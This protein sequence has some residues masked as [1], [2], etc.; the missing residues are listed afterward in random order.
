MLRIVTGVFIAMATLCVSNLARAQE[1]YSRAGWY[2]GLGGAVAFPTGTDGD[3]SL[4]LN[5]RAGYRGKWAGGEV[6]FEWFES[7]DTKLA[8]DDA[9]ALTLDGKLYFLAGL[10]DT[11]PPLAR[12]FQP[13]A[14][15]GFGYM[16]FDFPSAVPRLTTLQALEYSDL[17]DWDFVIRAGAGLDVY[18]TRNIA[19]SVDATYVF[20]TSNDLDELEWVSFGWGLL[21]R[22]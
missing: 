7:L 1:D 6:H 19:I 20:A 9:W 18:L 3:E 10:E 11:L 2:L 17:D 22:F 13:F 4:G 5:A 21:Y 12:R 8:I 14:T 15:A 16:T